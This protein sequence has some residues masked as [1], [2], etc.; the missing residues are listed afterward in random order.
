MTY[1]FLHIE[2]NLPQLSEC[3]TGDDSR[4]HIVVGPAY[5]RMSAQAGWEA[6]QVATL[7]D[8]CIAVFVVG[9]SCLR[10]TEVESDEAQ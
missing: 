3:A 1:L 2:G 6:L 8:V 10:N 4:V 7:Q 9:S 5:V